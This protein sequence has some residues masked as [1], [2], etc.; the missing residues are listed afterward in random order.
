MKRF[1][2]NGPAPLFTNSFLLITEAGHGIIIDPCAETAQYDALLKQE[3]A[4]LTHIFCTHG[5]YDHVGSAQ[6]LQ[7]E[8]KATLYCDAQDV[9]GTELYPLHAA[10]AGFGEGETIAVDELKFTVWHTPGHTKG[11]VC[12][13]C[14]DMLFTGDTLFAGD[15][16]RTD[17][18][19]GSFTDMVAS[20]KKLKMLPVPP[21]TKVLPGHED[22]SSFG[23][24]MEHN[25]FL[26]QVCG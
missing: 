3:N 26:R 11:S 13:L 16:G 24:E 22:F 6:A 20:C 19:G 25:A 7:A 14:E 5:H 2:L 10:D 8:W 15:T 21:Q 17:M 12:I 18:P 4:V 9:K 23:Y 1:H